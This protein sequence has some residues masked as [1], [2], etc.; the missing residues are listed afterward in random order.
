MLEELE[1]TMG[2]EGS[3]KVYRQTLINATPP[4]VP[5]IGVYLTDLVFIEGIQYFIIIIII[6][7]FYY[8]KNIKNKQT[9][10]KKTKKTKKKTI[11]ANIR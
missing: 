1:A 8:K 3:F 7:F 10:K 4:C 6:L 2:M 5:Y 11:A 9:N